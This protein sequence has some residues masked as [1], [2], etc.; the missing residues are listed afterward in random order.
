MNVLLISQ[1]SYKALKETRRIID[2][3]AER[4]GTRTWQTSITQQGLLALRKLLKKT[5]RRNS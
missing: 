4:K 5:A 2:Q 3:F 1:C